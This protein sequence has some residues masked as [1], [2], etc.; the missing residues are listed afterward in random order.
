MLS[1]ES[2]ERAKKVLEIA[3]R[4]CNDQ[5]TKTTLHN[6]YLS[7]LQAEDDLRSHIQ[8]IE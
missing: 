1:L 8:D 3:E 5:D 2:A 4:A 7:T 6:E